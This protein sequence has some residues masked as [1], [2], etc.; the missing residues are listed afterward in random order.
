MMKEKRRL[1]I[2]GST[3]SIGRNTCD[4]VRSLQDDFEIVGLA[5][6]SSVEVMLRQ[7]NEFTPRVVALADEDSARR[8]KEEAPSTTQVLSGMDGLKTVAALEEADSIVCSV[9]GAAGLLPVM[10]AIQ[11]GKNILLANKEVLVTAGEIV[12]RLARERG[13][14]L[15]PVD[16][17]HSAVH[18][19]LRGESISNVR[20]LILTA[21]GGPFFGDSERDLSTVTPA[22]ALQHP[23]WDMGNKITIDSATLMNKALEVIEAKWLFGMDL[24][25]IDVVIHPESIIHSLVEFVDGAIMAQM[26]EPDMRIPIQYALT[27]PEREPR[28]VAAFDFVKNNRLTF[29]EADAER[30]PCLRLGREAAA[31]GGTMPTVLNAANEVAVENFLKKEIRFTEIPLWIEAA[32]ADHKLIASPTIEDILATDA[33][34]RKE[35]YR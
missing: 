9:V 35:I 33:H 15:I 34:V 32:M 13:C 1:V 20:R 2:L 31:M 11:A 12:T 26:N 25:K 23:R 22:E 4:V 19:C 5:A 24:G 6:G 17:E 28:Q 14:T 7:I 30:F 27:Y 8:L 16:S 10:E 18:Q 21:S 3:G 29:L